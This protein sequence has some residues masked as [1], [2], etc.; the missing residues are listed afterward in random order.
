MSVE[1]LLLAMSEDWSPPESELKFLRDAIHDLNN[2]V[3]VILATSELLQLDAAEGKP[4]SRCQL[5]EQ[6]SLEAREILLGMS[7]RYFD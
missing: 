4:K 3:G 2:R 5:I 7:E 1:Y 6:K